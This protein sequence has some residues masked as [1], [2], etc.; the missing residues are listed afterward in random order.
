MA[1]IAYIRKK[2]TPEAAAIIKVCDR[3]VTQYAAAGRDL[4]LRQLYYQLVA[5]DHFPDTRKW[6][7]LPTGKW[8]RDDNGTKN[9]EPN[10]DWLG[11]VITDARMAG[12]IDW[13][14]MVDRTRATAM[15]N[16][17]ANPAQLIENVAGAYHEDLWAKQEHRVMCM[18][19][20]EAL[21][22]MLENTCPELD[23]PY[24]SC[25]GYMSMSEM[26]RVAQ[27]IIRW[28]KTF[29]QDTIILHLGDHDPSGIDMTRDIGERLAVFCE[30]HG[31]PA[32]DVRRIAL[33]MEQ[34]RQYDPPPN[35][36]KLSDSR[37][38]AYIAEY[39]DESWELDAMPAEDLEAL[40]TESIT[41]LLDGPAWDEAREHME[42]QRGTI[43]L[44]T[45]NWDEAVEHCSEL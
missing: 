31:C 10:Y 44:V 18:I 5:H 30:A 29:G 26:W 39:G 43:S 23:V 36:A 13:N 34:V 12:L 41:E 45:D 22:G 1:K 35:P 21:S 24:L 38:A 16:F 19:E 11:T 27:R 33:T 40:I 7:R 37:C 14:T 2:F 6:A 32:P 28:H 42:Q 25:R 20:K 17:W 8:V 3:I 15:N 4:T 9:A